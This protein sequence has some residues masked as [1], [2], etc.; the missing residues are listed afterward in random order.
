MPTFRENPYGAFN[1]LV[2]LGGSQGDGGMPAK[3][4]LHN[5]RKIAD[6]PAIFLLQE[7]R[8]FGI[9]H[10]FGDSQHFLVTGHRIIECHAGGIPALSIV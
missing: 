9:S 7:K 1:Y 3:G 2:S 6:T 5:R 8:R 10:L 4:D